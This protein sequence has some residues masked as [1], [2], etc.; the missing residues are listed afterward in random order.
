M[1]VIQ[2]MVC[3]HTSDWSNAEDVIHCS[4]LL[5]KSRVALLKFIS[6]PR[7]ELTAAT[8][9][10]KVSRVIREDVYINDEMFWTDSQI[11]LG[12]TN[13][14]AQRFKIFVANRVQKIRDKTN[15]RQCIM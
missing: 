9:S 15:K 3:Q 13:S 7:L 1:H 12:Y 11:V 5:G 2:V 4:L 10:V 8:I 14:Y 6:I